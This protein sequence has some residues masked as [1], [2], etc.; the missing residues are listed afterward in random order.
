MALPQVVSGLIQ[1]VT[2]SQV[3]SM[4]QMEGDGT[5][6]IP[7]GIVDV[8]KA[9]KDPASPFAI[10]DVPTTEAPYDGQVCFGVFDI[11]PGHD[12]LN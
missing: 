10:P 6:L 8:A 2:P 11:D 3:C 9:F 4:Y 5:T 7:S 1:T 12:G